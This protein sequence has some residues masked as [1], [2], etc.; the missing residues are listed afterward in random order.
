MW[1]RKWYE[2]HKNIFCLSKTS[3]GRKLLV[4]RTMDFSVNACCY[5]MIMSTAPILLSVETPLDFLRDVIA[6][7]FVL[8]LDDLYESKDLYEYKDIY[9]PC[10]NTS[11]AE[12]LNVYSEFMNLLIQ[13]ENPNQPDAEDPM[14]IEINPIQ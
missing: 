7:T 13:E 1:E 4:R 6:F 11:H 3:L 10:K 12:Q 8:R 5:S 9:A 14:T 2:M